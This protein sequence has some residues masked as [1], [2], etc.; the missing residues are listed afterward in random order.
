MR[1]KNK[2]TAAMLSFFT[3][4]IGGHKLY[5]GDTGGFIFFILLFS[6]SISFFGLPATAI[7]G[8]FEGM[9]FL[10]MDYNEFDRKYNHG[11]VQRVDT[12]IEKRRSEQM[13]RYE[14]RAQREEYSAPQRDH[15]VRSNPFK[16]SGLAKYKDFDLDGAIEDF[17][18]GLD[19]DPN[20]VA[21]NF[22]LACAYSLSEKKDEA[23]KY[24][25]RAVS[26]GF[27]DFERILSHDDLAF[28]RIQPEFDAFKQSNYRVYVPKTA[29]KSAPA[30]ASTSS[31]TIEIE[32][33]SQLLPQLQKLAEL[34][35][36]GILT[37]QEYIL[38]KRKL[39]R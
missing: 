38:E 24:L 11:Y 19:I 30:T 7:L 17:K 5:L 32:D 18:Q 39:E 23:Y 37:E 1:P 29:P 15:R 27:T 33:N 34:K 21:I 26:S 35:E 20:D 14:T 10:N 16:S 13:N 3:G 9:K 22:N 28:V 25:A 6:L 36:R 31:G 2:F 12:R 4:W 8:F